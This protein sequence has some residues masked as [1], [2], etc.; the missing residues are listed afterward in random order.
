MSKITFLLRIKTRVRLWWLLTLNLVT[1]SKQKQ[2]T[3][4]RSTTRLVWIFQ[5]SCTYFRIWQFWC[6]KSWQIRSSC[7]CSSTSTVTSKLQEIMLCSKIGYFSMANK[8]VCIWLLRPKLSETKFTWRL[9]NW[10][11]R[12]VKNRRSERQQ[13]TKGWVQGRRSKGSSVLPT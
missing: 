5:L 13:L 11:R 1:L 9:I 7:A 4:S 8:I 12:S 10:S 2:D 6:I 3:I